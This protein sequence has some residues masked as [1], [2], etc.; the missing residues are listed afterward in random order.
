VAVHKSMI[1]TGWLRIHDS[2]SGGSSPF[3]KRLTDPLSSLS[4]PACLRRWLNLTMYCS[5]PSPSCRSLSSCVCVL[6]LLLESLNAALNAHSNSFQRYSSVFACPL[7]IRSF[8][9]SSSCS[10]QSWTSSPSMK[11]RMRATLLYGFIMAFLLL[12]TALHPLNTRRN[13]LASFESPLK[14]GGGAPYSAPPSPWFVAWVVIVCAWC[15][16]EVAGMFVGLVTLWIIV[17][18]IPVGPS[19]VSG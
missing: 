15:S 5:T 14:N 17:E 18:S 16:V 19:G 11:V 4:N 7:V 2:S 9:R 8:K 12:F 1:V 6:S 13:L 3:R 10:F